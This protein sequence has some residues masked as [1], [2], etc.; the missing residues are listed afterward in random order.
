MP[1]VKKRTNTSDR[2][3]KK[4]DVTDSA[5]GH[6]TE[7][8]CS[9]CE[10]SGFLQLFN[11]MPLELARIF[12]L[13]ERKVLKG[14]VLFREG[15]PFRGI[16]A[17]KEGGVKSCLLTPQS[18]E[19]ILGFYLPGELLGMESLRATHYQTTAIVLEPGR[20]CCL[21]L[22]QLEL[23]GDSYQRF[24]EQLIQTLTNHLAQQ[25]QQFVL[26]ARQSAEERLAAFLLNMA[27]R[28]ARHGLV[29]TS[30]RLIMLRQDIAYFLG[31]S[32]ET[33]SRTLTR[34]QTKK[35]LLAVGKQI[36]LLDTPG[37]QAIAYSTPPP[38]SAPAG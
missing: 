38:D 27:E 20:V 29:G 28:Y 15:E 37:L 4:D 13:R 11:E 30:F 33:V 10:F 8:T 17:I 22:D 36:Y 23:L 26:S 31:I 12:L 7:V 16:Y 18:T 9:Q 5:V 1:F 32:I 14:E 24:Q 2:T 3:V 19:R 6:R 34:F 21:P 35:L 25:Q